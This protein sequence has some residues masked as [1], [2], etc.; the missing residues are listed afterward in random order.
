MNPMI[1]GKVVTIGSS[2]RDANPYIPL[3]S[4]SVTGSY[5]IST[6]SATNKLIANQTAVNH[7][8]AAGFA[9]MKQ[10]VDPEKMVQTAK[11]AAAKV[12]TTAAKAEKTLKQIESAAEVTAASAPL[13]AKLEAIQAT[14]QAGEARLQA[15][16]V[17]QRAME[18]KLATVCACV[19]M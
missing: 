5:E 6:L 7:N 1:V 15:M 8:L 18:A 11:I 2:A 17:R 9:S 3:P 19:V 14:Q 10:L 12:E 13:M 4:V 16:E